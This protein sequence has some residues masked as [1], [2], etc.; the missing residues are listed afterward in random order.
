MTAHALQSSFLSTHR[1]TLIASAV[2]VLHVLAIWA[3]QT[4]LLM[5]VVE[6]VVPVEVL[7]QIIEPPKPIPPK[8]TPPPAPP[9]PAKPAVSK[10]PT[11]VTQAAPKLLAVEDATPT[12]NSPV[13]QLISPPTPYSP[14]VAVAAVAPSVQ[15]APPAKVVLPSSDAEYLHNPKPPY[16]P[17]SKRLSEQGHV[18]LRIYIG[19]DGMPQK[20]ELQ[21][22]SGFDRLDQAALAVV[23]QWR[24][25]PGKRGDVPE[26]MW[27]GTTISYVLE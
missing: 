17:M 8:E 10:P 4:G 21:K 20:A 6:L 16:P 26:A 22:T 14:S 2:L 9:P 7:A 24:F 18:K 13:P 15:L 27:M 23:M 1:N 5:R 12:P 19:A 11:P 3:L 25:V